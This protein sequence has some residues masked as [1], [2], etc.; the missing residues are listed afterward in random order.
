[1]TT[2]NPHRLAVGQKLYFESSRNRHHHGREVTIVKLGRKWATL[3]M[4]HPAYRIDLTS[5]CGDGRGY[6]SP[7]RCW[8]SREACEDHNALIADWSAFRQ[9][10][11][12]HYSPPPDITPE[13]IREAAERLHIEIS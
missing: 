5:L 11:E 12:R 10:V 1:M 13:R 4:G 8:L 7:G 6:S 2:T 9:T 3:D